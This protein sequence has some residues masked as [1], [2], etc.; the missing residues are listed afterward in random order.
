M[1]RTRVSTL[2]TSGGQA[3]MY[4]SMFP[5]CA[6]SVFMSSPL[7]ACRDES[8]VKRHTAVGSPSRA[9]GPA[10]LCRR[11]PGIGAALVGAGAHD[12]LRNAVEHPRADA[13]LER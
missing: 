13:F 7:P 11:R 6:R 4:A 5:G 12:L 1:F 10:Q 9:Y 8:S 3:A 2:R